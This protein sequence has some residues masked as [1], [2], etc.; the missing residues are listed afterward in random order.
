VA[1]GVT[2]GLGGSWVTSLG[3]KWPWLLAD[4]HGVAGNLRGSCLTL[5]VKDDFKK[6]WVTSHGQE[7]SLG[8]VGG[9][10][11]S[12]RASGSRG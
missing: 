7:L 8:A 4:V 12:W 6:S 11:G 3:H 9:L 2:D 5:G 1:S 10:R